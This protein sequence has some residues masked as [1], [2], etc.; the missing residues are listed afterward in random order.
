[1]KRSKTK[2]SGFDKNISFIT[3]SDMFRTIT[4]FFCNRQIL[5]K[6]LISYTGLVC[7]LPPPF[8]FYSFISDQIMP[9]PGADA[10]I[11]TCSPSIFTLITF[12]FALS[13][14]FLVFLS[15]PITLAVFK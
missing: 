2:I 4:E 1:M 8:I 12:L 5:F 9:L 14:P 15:L 13:A 3:L 10:F 7:Y 6:R 11:Q